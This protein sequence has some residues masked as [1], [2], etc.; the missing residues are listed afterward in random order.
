M[1]GVRQE[2]DRDAYRKRKGFTTGELMARAIEKGE[3]ALFLCHR[4]ELVRKPALEFEN[5]FGCPATIEMGNDSADDAPAVFASIKTM[6]NRIKSGK[7][8]AGEFQRVIVDED[9]GF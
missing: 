2:F 7:W 6:H 5:D 3:R 8:K 1:E 4:R 9:I